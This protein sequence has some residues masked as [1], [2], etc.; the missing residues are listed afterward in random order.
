[1]L[2]LLEFEEETDQENQ[3]PIP[4]AFRIDPARLRNSLQI[5]VP[6]DVEVVLYCSSRREI[7]SARAA[8]ELQRIGIKKVWVLDS[9][10]NGWRGNG[11]PLSP[12]PAASEA[13]AE[14]LGIRLPNV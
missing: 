8:L 6:G 1:L 7:V 13:V 10:L 11:L 12:F 9:G 14:R 4:G 2:D 3:S 5:T